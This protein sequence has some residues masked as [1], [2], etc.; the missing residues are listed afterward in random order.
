M[1]CLSKEA[2]KNS[3]E[4]LELVFNARLKEGTP[5]IYW[6]YLS[7]RFTDDEFKAAV[8]KIILKE[9]FFPAISVFVAYKNQSLV[10]KA[11]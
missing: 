1:G 10:Q 5:K 4:K 3:M 8:E 11:H 9:R 7:T 2:F 6:K